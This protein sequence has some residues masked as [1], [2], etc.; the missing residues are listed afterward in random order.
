MGLGTLACAVLALLVAR[1]GLRPVAE[2]TETVRGVTRHG[3]AGLPGGREW[4]EE[5]R[6]LAGESDR[7]L[8]RLDESYAR[9]ERFTADAAHELRTPLNNL[10]LGTSLLL[11]RERTADE[12]RRHAENCQDQ[13]Q[14]LHRLVESLLFLARVEDGGEALQCEACDAGQICREVV[15]FH[16]AAAEAAGVVLSSEGGAGLFADALLVKQALGNLVSNA[17]D[18][19][20]AGGTV[21][22]VVTAAGGGVTIA[23]AD[24]GSGIPAGHLPRVF[25]RF[26]RADAARAAKP[27]G[28]AGLGLAIVAMVMRW[29]GGTATAESRAGMGT[30]MTLRFPAGGE[31]T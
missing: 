1:R 15:E 29:H 14:R 12:Y 16:G 13:Y 3:A 19:T 25:D 6:V 11:S 2:I 10:M 4:P 21:S 28:G 23:V 5:L 8:R 17:V 7:M 9:L 22:V 30:V 18:H 31:G 24:T 27:R 26:Y 20:P